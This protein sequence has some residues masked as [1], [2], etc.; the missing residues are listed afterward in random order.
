MI[1]KSEIVKP[2]E[3]NPIHLKRIQDKFGSVD[4]ENDF[5]D[6]TLSKYYKT[7]NIDPTTGEIE[8]TLYPLASFKDSLTK[9]RKAMKALI[10]VSKTPEGEDDKDIQNITLEVRNL[11]NFYRTHIRNNYP[12]QYKTFK[13]LLG[14]MNT[15]GGGAG[16]AS[17]TPGTGAQYATPFAFGKKNKETKFYY[18]LGYKKVPKMKKKLYEIGQESND[19]QSKRIEAFDTIE[20]E[21]NDIYKI[22]SNSKNETVE[23]YNENPGSYD[24]VFPTDLILDYINDI[25]ILLTSE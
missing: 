3:I 9:L 10:L 8:H 12:D 23:F 5:F 19:F 22:L 1:N 13:N 15:T 16:A 14:E 21:M 25:K 17:F 2:S 7:T 11:F 4:M 18:K 24:V 6:S 20:K